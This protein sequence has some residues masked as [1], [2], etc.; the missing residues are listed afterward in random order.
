MNVNEFGKLFSLPVVGQIYAQPLY[1]PGVTVNGGIHNVLIVATEEDYVYAF[2]ADSAGAPLWT[3]SLVDIAHGAGTGEGPMQ[4]SVLSGCNDLTPNIGITGTPVIDSVAGTIYV[5]AKS[6]TG[7]TYIQRL[8]TLNLATGAEKSPGPAVI[9]ASVPAHRRRI[10]QRNTGFLDPLYEHNRPGLLLL[11]GS[12]FIAYASHC[13][14]SPYH[15]WILA[16]NASTLAQQ[17]VFVTTPN[18]GLGGFWMA[19]A[20]LAADESFIY[21][22]SGNGTFDSTNV[23]ATELGDTVVKLSTTNGILSLQDYFTPSDQ[24][25]L[26]TDDTDLGS[27]G[28]LVVPDPPGSAPHSLVAGG[29]EDIV[30]A[31]NRDHMTLGNNHFENR[32]NCNSNDPQILEESRQVGFLFSIPA[33]VSNNSL[34]YWA[35]GDMAGIDSSREWSSPSSVRSQEIQLDRVVARRDPVDL[36]QWNDYWHCHFVGY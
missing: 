16:Y 35:A 27:G 12:V 6:T 4:S 10:E 34:Y 11:N 21:A 2:D 17:S 13:D 28:V 31:V 32:K 7:S 29:K 22:A 23:P 3:A 19:G 30:Y 20:G 8:H 1:V 26:A 15:G 36:F 9:T 18:G 33:S 25:C 14:S 5:V 24:L